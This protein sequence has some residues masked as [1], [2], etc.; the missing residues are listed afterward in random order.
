LG[1][2]GEVDVN[3]S[4]GAAVKVGRREQNKADKLARI[5]AAARKLFT[6][7]GYEA[8]CTREIAEE[9]GLSV[10]TIFF[11]ARDKG[12]LC[13]L[14]AVD[15]L[16]RLFSQSFK[17]VDQAKPLLD[18][19]TSFFS[20]TFIDAAKN[21]SLSRILIKE[22]VI[23][24]DKPKTDDWVTSRVG[25]LLDVAL[26]RGEVGFKESTAFVA[27]T[28]NQMYLAEMRDWIV[29]DKPD[30]AEGLAT[31]RR[32]LFLLFEGLMYGSAPALR[33]SQTKKSAKKSRILPADPTV[34]G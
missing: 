13:C 24:K 31:L 33:R 27:R 18:Q 32:S 11:Y 19:L 21:P 22:M 16:H 28:V 6:S 8:T 15:R 30:P 7:K 2:Q 20:A 25:Q 12:D 1:Y 26:S 5:K 17:K 3:S 10:G 34:K 23:Y 29:G 4:V 14:M 9:A